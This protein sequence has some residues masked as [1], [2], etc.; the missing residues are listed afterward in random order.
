MVL[1]TVQFLQSMKTHTKH[2]NLA[3]KTLSD[4]FRKAIFRVLKETR[5]EM[6]EGENG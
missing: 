6:N 1:N 2:F 4:P 3:R 5:F